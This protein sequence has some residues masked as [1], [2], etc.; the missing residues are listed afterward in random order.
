MKGNV[1]WGTA[2]LILGLALAL[3]VPSFAQSPTPP[4]PD[5]SAGTDRTVTV[6][7]TATIRFP[8]NAAIFPKSPRWTISVAKIP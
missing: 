7:G 3:S 1:K 2:G 4:T 5:T 8:C 6:S